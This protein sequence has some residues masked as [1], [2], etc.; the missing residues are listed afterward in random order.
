MLSFQTPSVYSSEFDAPQLDGFVAYS[1]AAL[2]QKGF[3]EWSGTPA[4][5]KSESV[6]E[7]D[8]V[9]KDIGG[10]RLAGVGALV[11]IHEPI[12]SI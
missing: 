4:V 1:D 3:N 12:L 8:S 6:V 10:G 5:A 9:G 7:P 2:S 11:S